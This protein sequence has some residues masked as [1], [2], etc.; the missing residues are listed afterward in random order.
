MAASDYSELV[1]CTPAGVLVP[2]VA[3]RIA[4]DIG[5]AADTGLQDPSVWAAGWSGVAVERWQPLKVQ[6]KMGTFVVLGGAIRKTSS[7]LDAETVGK[8]P[9][10]F[11]PNRQVKS[12]TVEITPDGYI[13]IVGSGSGSVGIYAMWMKQ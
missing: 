12:S 6:M 1:A 9:E 7:W 10:I 3:S 8:V 2:K 4:T 13:R 5:F 11:N